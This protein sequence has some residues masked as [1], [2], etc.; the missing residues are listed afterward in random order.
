LKSFLIVHCAN[1]TK[2]I[3]IH[4][5]KSRYH[6]FFFDLSI[7]SNKQF[8]FIG[9]GG[10]YDKLINDFSIL[11]NNVHAVG[12]CLVM[13]KIYSHTKI[14][15]TSIHLDALVSFDRGMEVKDQMSVLNELWLHN[16]KTDI[17]PPEKSSHELKDLNAKCVLVIKK[18]LLS[19]NQIK[20]HD[21]RAKKSKTEIISKEEMIQYFNNSN[22]PTV[23]DVKVVSNDHSK[24]ILYIGFSNKKKQDLT[25]LKRFNALISGIGTSNI[26]C[27]FS[28][29][30]IILQAL[31]MKDE[32]ETVLKG[33]F[34]NLNQYRNLI[35]PLLKQIKSQTT[36][37]FIYS[38][39]DDS[40]ILV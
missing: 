24:D 27:V 16:T 20:I 35:V 30:K 34:T 10:R 11:E 40:W 37:S 12:I 8:Q 18:N 15:E 4:P 2:G 5:F 31:S 29:Q 6:G 17:I 38:I 13:N 25:P 19:K 26:I 14:L 39:Y 33:V 32:S 36:S 3:P 22:A 28:D 9:Y 23:K 7:Y 21:L 1:T